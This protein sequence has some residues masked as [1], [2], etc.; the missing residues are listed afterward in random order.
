[1]IEKL[2]NKIQEDWRRIGGGRSRGRT[3]RRAKR[4]AGEQREKN[5]NRMKVR[6]ATG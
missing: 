5:D 3:K 1:V 6:S 4:R 2:Q